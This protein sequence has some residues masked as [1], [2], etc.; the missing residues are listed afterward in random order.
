MKLAIRV[1]ILAILASLVFIMVGRTSELFLSLARRFSGSLSER[2]YRALFRLGSFASEVLYQWCVNHPNVPRN[3]SPDHVFLVLNFL[4]CPHP[5]WEV[6]AAFFKLSVP[7]YRKHLI[8]GL[9]F[10]NT[11]LPKVILIC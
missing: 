11:V 5:S 8:A 2:T 4:K 7:T 6:A 10:I 9:K 3:F 1:L